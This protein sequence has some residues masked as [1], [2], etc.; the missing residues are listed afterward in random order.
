M[1]DYTQL[2]V[3]Y[4]NGASLGVTTYPEVPADRPDEFCVVELTGGSLDD[5]FSARPQLDVDCW[6]Q[7]RARAAQI[8]CDVVSAALAMPDGT[9][10][11]FNVNITSTYNNPDLDSGTPRY[12]V[13]L[14]LTTT[15]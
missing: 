4:L 14:E 9:E 10:N 1:V 3:R 12:T 2:L 5:R 15:N 7:T 13:G 6:A 11:V 8:A